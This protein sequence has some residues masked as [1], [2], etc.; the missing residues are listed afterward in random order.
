MRE[1]IL[2]SF[3]YGLKSRT[4]GKVILLN[5]ANTLFADMAFQKAYSHTEKHLLP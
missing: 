3:F 5:L 1:R 2:P 4:I